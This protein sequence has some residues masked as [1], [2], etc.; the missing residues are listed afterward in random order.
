MMFRTAAAAGC[1][2]LAAGFGSMAHAAPPPAGELFISPAGEPFRQPSGGPDPLRAW[3][4]AA[5]ADGDGKIARTE[6]AADHDRFFTIADANKNDVIA[7][8]DITV[9]EYRTVPEILGPDLPQRRPTVRSGRP[10]YDDGSGQRGEV[11]GRPAKLKAPEYRTGAGRFSLLNEP[12]PLRAGDA[13][14]DFQVTRE[15]WAAAAK[16]RFDRLD[17]NKD[18]ALTIEELEP[19]LP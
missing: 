10:G 4:G 15:E 13:D 7:G 12:Q 17:A 3:F 8:P 14:M 11:D 19:R 6:F 1:L 16:R 5:D 2:L 18:D 9:Y